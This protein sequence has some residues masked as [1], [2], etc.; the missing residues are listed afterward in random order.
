MCYRRGL[1]SVICVILSVFSCR[2]CIYQWV[3]LS[4]VSENNYLLRFIILSI[5]ST[6]LM[7]LYNPDINDIPKLTYTVTKGIC[8]CCD[9]RQLSSIIICHV[10][11]IWWWDDDDR[12]WETI[13]HILYGLY[14][15]LIKDLEVSVNLVS[16]NPFVCYCLSDIDDRVR[17]KF[18][19]SISEWKEHGY[20][21]TN[22]RTKG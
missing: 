19:L 9:L 21:E 12:W 14:H 11:A 4:Y 13:I 17:I 10:Y 7:K 16:S 5:W 1:I 15:Q 22:N 20:T 18:Y 3:I 8:P 2:S 6:I